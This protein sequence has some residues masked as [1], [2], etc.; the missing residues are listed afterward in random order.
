MQQYYCD[1]CKTLYK[2]Q[3]VCRVC[4]QIID[5]TIIIDVH[6]QGNK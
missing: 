4:G 2:E 3:G 6:K 1:Y 5:K